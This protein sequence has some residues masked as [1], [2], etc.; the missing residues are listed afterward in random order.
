MC[1]YRIHIAAVQHGILHP[2][3]SEADDISEG[4]DVFAS[5]QKD[6]LRLAGGLHR[7]SLSGEVAHL[8]DAALRAD[9]DDLTAYQIRSRPLIVVLAAVHGKAVPDAVDFSVIDQLGFLFPVDRGEFRAVSHAAECLLRN[10]HVQTGNVAVIVH[11]DIRRIGVAADG[12]RRECAVGR[13]IR[14]AAGQQTCRQHG[15]KRQ[16]ASYPFVSVHTDD[17]VL[18]LLLVVR[19]ANRHNSFFII[20]AA[21]LLH[22]RNFRRRR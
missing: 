8:L 11:I 21:A 4:R 3:V 17:G 1:C 6:R 5:A 12:D 9:G 2:A 20:H 16:S 19:A 13:R 10:I 22:N 18:S 15:Q 14:D 7:D